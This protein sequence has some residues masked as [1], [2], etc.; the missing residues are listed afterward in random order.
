MCNHHKDQKPKGRYGSALEHGAAH[1]HD[2]QSWSR[3]TFMKNLGIAG[4]VSMLLGRTPLTALSSSPLSMALNTTESDNI[5]VLIRFK[6]GNDGL[7]MIVPVFDYGTYKNYR[8]TIAIPE[9]QLIS[10]SDSFGMPNTMASVQ[11]MWEDGAM[12][13]VNSVGYDDQNLSHFRSTDIWSSASDANELDSSGWLGRLLDK[14]FPDY[15]TDP[16][17]SPQ[18]IQIGGS[19]TSIFYNRDSVNL[20]VTVNDP[21]ELFQIAQNGELYDALDVPECRYGEQLSFVRTVAN[22]TSR[23][24]EIIASAYEA[25]TN[26]IEYGPNLGEQLA[27]VARLI[28]GGLETKLYMVT[29]DGF[30]THANQNGSHPNLM[31]NLTTS[32]KAFY[33][34]LAAS[35]VAHRVLS[36]TFSEFGRRIEQNASGGTDHGAAAP[37]ILFGE[38]LNGN[39]FLGAAPDLQ[40][41]DQVGN[42]QYDLDFRQI[43]S[44][45]L[46]NWLCIDPNL[47]D[48]VLGRS[49]ERL[50]DLGL[51]C[52]TPTSTIEQQAALLNHR[53]L[54]DQGRI[55]VEYTLP[56]SMPVKVQI[57]DILGRPVETLFEGYQMPGTHRH[58]FQT[59]G[60]RISSG[61]YIYHIMAGRRAYSN[62]IRIA[63]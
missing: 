55:V 38:G 21:E 14:Q 13:V 6:G 63:R 46:E 48:E 11:G 40:N 29:L 1:T 42:L 49:F 61:I 35:G 53:A 45:V 62:K 12:K 44:T 15:I 52:Q 18:A 30:D 54:Y 28:K 24:A 36:M 58:N 16:P 9:D 23:Y 51:T 34:D 26:A 20:G 4:S 17:T 56:E 43:Y 59:W 8:P 31:Y 22:S 47:V 25:S 27:L 5:L 32:V 19:G 37:M 2:H 7:N 60:N 3:R 41:L 57:F 10:L 39:G 50:P 33:E